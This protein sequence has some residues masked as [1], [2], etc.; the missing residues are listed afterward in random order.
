MKAARVVRLTEF[1]DFCWSY[2]L[3]EPPYNAVAVGRKWIGPNPGYEILLPTNGL[4]IVFSGPTARDW[5]FTQPRD[6]QPQPQAEFELELEGELT[7]VSEKERRRQEKR[8][9]D[10]EGEEDVEMEEDDSDDDFNV[11]DEGKPAVDGEKEKEESGE[12]VPDCDCV[13][14]SFIRPK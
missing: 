8:R 12:R 2:L 1:R 3:E 9:M 7:E 4:R 11:D 13:S 14:M 6:S 10:E 5:R